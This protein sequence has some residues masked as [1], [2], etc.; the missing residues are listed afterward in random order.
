MHWELETRLAP[1]TMARIVDVPA[2]LS[3]WRPRSDAAGVATF[4][5]SDAAAPWN[6][7]TWRVEFEGGNARATRTEG[8]PQVSLDIRELSQAYFGTPSLPELRR[9]DRITV[10][11]EAGYRALADLLDG[12]P[13][14]MNDSF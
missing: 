10:H 11:D 13:M 14:W 5:V 1:T 2:A 7:A 6:Q 8:A 12:P 9:A 4:A 3:A